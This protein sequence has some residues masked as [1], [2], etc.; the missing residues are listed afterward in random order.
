MEKQGAKTNREEDEKLVR[1]FLIA[2]V[3]AQPLLGWC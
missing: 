1:N 3:F 2:R